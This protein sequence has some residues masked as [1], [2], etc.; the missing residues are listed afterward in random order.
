MFASSFLF[1]DGRARKVC[2]KSHSVPASEGLD[3]SV[4]QLFMT[5]TMA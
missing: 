5:K 4:R 2:G 3:L 1:S